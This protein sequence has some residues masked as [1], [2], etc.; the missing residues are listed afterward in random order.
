MDKQELITVM[1]PVYNVQGYLPQCIESIINQTYSNLEI[2]LIDDG[3]TDEC[4][5]ICDKFALEDERIRVVHRQN[6]GRSVARNTALEQAKGEYLLFVD[7]D[8]WIDSDCVEVLYSHIK[9][10]NAQLALGRYRSVYTDK[11]VDGST[12][13]L[14]VLRGEEP[15]EFY[16]RGKGAYQN[17][18]SVC[19]KLYSRELLLDIRFEEGKYFEDV[20]FVTRVFSK[21]TSCVYL[22]TALYNYNIATPTSITFA[23]VTDL[24][25]RDEI[26]CFYEK[27]EFLK[28]R[29][30]E[31]LAATYAFFRY[32]RLLT[33]YRDSYYADTKKSKGYAKRIRKIIKND[34]AKIHDLCKA[35]EGVKWSRMALKIF[36]LSSTMYRL[37][38]QLMRWYGERKKRHS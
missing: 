3:S 9:K 30:R 38:F 36:L 32:E 15:L 20:M 25:F 14:M 26:P 23:G 27:E 21:C 19:V 33:Y 11:I 12:N 24:T 13:E 17:T 29:G 37:Y 1:V 4:P 34:R 28:Q 35:G 18:N 8:D 2:L 5:K 7:G 31:D 22:D 16:V 10:E 6:G